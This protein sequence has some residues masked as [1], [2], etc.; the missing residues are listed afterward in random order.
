MVGI[1]CPASIKRAL[2]STPVIPGIWMSAIKHVVL[3]R[4]R[5]ARKTAADGKA[6]TVK[7]NDCMSLLIDPRK[8]SSSSTIAINGA[9]DIRLSGIRAKP[10]PIQAIDTL[11]R[12]LGIWQFARR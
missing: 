2:S 8:N 11:S 12:Q 7:P 3:S 1:L 6:S 4:R 5:D 10:Y 9:L